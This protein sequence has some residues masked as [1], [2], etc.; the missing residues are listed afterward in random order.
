MYKH[1]LIATDGSEFAARG[2]AHGLALA[3]SAGARVTIVTATEMWTVMG[4]LRETHDEPA[5]RK[6]NPIAEYENAAAAVA[7]RVLA[8]AAQQSAAQGV[9]CE[10]V[11]VPD[12]HPAEGIVTTAENRGCDLIVMASH[13]RRGLE[14]LML[15]SQANEVVSLSK[16]PT[17]IV[18]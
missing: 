17:L 14:R 11:H 9:A 7:A 4:M 15:G 16:V 5:L 18:K 12:M 10:T 3:K 8:Q 13:G 2:L 1:I 6:G